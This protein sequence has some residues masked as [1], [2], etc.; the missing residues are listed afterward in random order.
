MLSAMSA[1][2]QEPGSQPHERHE[3][4]FYVAGARD[5]NVADLERLYERSLPALCVWIRARVTHGL[6]M[7]IDVEDL[8]QEVWLRALAGFARFDPERSSFRTWLIGIAKNVLLESLREASTSRGRLAATGQSS[9]LDRVPD[10]VTTLTR[11]V[12]RNDDVQHMHAF[13]AQ[14]DEDE[15]ALLLGHGIEGLTLSEIGLR[16]DVSAETA[17]KRWQ[18]L[19]ARLRDPAVWSNV[20]GPA[21]A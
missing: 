6:R 17:G 16:L 4:S 21:S 19:V 18:R 9:I 13:I 7:Q 20:L 1:V 11:A 10:S 14:L 3:T 5:G 2:P 8:L 12:T 15:R